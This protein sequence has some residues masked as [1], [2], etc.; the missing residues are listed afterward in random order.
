AQPGPTA[1]AARPAQEDGPPQPDQARGPFEVAGTGS[2][3][4]LDGLAAQCDLLET[5]RRTTTTEDCADQLRLL[6]C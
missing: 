4:R 1:V 2:R 5:G 3:R 6:P